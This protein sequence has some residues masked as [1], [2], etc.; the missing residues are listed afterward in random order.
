MVKGSG[1]Q[2]RLV[3]D[4]EL[5]EVT[6]I[7]VIKCGLASVLDLPA[8]QHRL[9]LDAVERY[10][11]VVSRALR[12]G[13]LLMAHDLIHRAERGLPIPDLY[14]QSDTF[15]KHAL[16]AEPDAAVAGHE[17]AHLRVDVDYENGDTPFSV[18]MHV[19]HV[20][21]GSLLFPDA[22]PSDLVHV[23]QTPPG[24]DQVL[25][26]AATTFSTAVANS[27]WIPLFKRLGR[28]VKGRVRAWKAA[29]S[30][31][32]A[33]GAHNVM[34]AIRRA[35][36]PVQD[37]DLPLVAYLFVVD[38]RQR[39]R[40]VTG[41][42][43]FDDHGK[44]VLTFPQLFKF[45]YWMQQGLK[46]MGLRLARLMP[47][48][49]VHR[50]HV[51][52]D[53][54]TLLAMLMAL[55]PPENKP[56]QRLR[57]ARAEHAKALRQKGGGGSGH[58]NPEDYMLRE[59]QRPKP[60]LQKN[61][62]SEEWTRYKETR[63]AAKA[64]MAKVRESAVFLAQK[65]RYDAFVA[66]E[67]SVV[68]S[69]FT[70]KSLNKRHW[71]LDASLT[72]DGVS[73]SL[74]FSRKVQRKA[75]GSKETKALKRRAATVV[76]GGNKKKPPPVVDY[77]V[78][79]P[80][81]LAEKDLCVLGCDPGRVNL[82]TV[83][84]MRRRQACGRVHEESDTWKLTRADYR[85]RSLVNM[86]DALQRDRARKAGLLT[87]WTK[88]GE[89]EAALNTLHSCDVLSYMAAYTPL[90]ERWWCLALQR[91]ESRSNFQ[92]YIGKRSVLDGFWGGIKRTMRQLHPDVA[93]KVA[94]GSAGPSM[95]PGGRG[96]QSVPTTGTY[97]A[98]RRAF[99]TV[100]TDEFRST[101]VSWA[102]GTRNELVYERPDGLGG[103]RLDHVPGKYSPVV[104][105][106]AA[107]GG[108]V[109]KE[110]AEVAKWR[111]DAAARKAKA[112]S[113]KTAAGATPP[114]PQLRRVVIRYPE[115]RG[116]RFDN[117]SGKYHDRAVD[118]FRGPRLRAP[119]GA[120]K[121][122]SAALTIA[123]LHCLTELGRPRPQ[124]FSRSFCMI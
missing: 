108:G 34:G 26:Y 30:S 64:A 42:Y 57:A 39:L 36:V 48:F 35:E 20:D 9:F 29:D 74:Q 17:N 23:R 18:S 56:T 16:M 4:G 80:T 103:R 109:N 49:K 98:C 24:F 118:P 102:S 8:V 78:D 59:I 105:L 38:V 68:R 76:A 94:Y 117:E 87:E 6:D 27:A 52:L 100:L 63:D 120:R 116:L 54:K 97:A 106:C 11:N 2:T 55:A 121:D 1:A 14:N 28:L 84:Y 99:D 113:W 79:L 115:V 12:R 66:L 32:A 31:L 119:E 96:E 3:E 67:V 62:T 72:T 46:S 53:C 37:G 85:K 58:T 19:A 60:L 122:R 95:R 89:G 112:S 77:D 71:D 33:L 111:K 40:A 82:A 123:R 50:A 7:R 101:V 65:V 69:L 44:K 90:Q 73:V 83:T 91:R 47:I 21:L 13:S 75:G 104:P 41:Q 5:H 81:Y 92:R 93:F 25:A 10:V 43:L 70:A 61:V 124:P 88:L 110:W 51:R 114:P 86:Q 15:W 22:D 107:T 45:N